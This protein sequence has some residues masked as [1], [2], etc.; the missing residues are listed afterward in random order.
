MAGSS[1]GDGGYEARQAAAEAKKQEARDAINLLFGQA[2]KGGTRPTREQFTMSPQELAQKRYL[3][4]LPLSGQPSLDYSG[5][6]PGPQI[7]DIDPFD[8]AAYNKALREWRQNQRA[9]GANRQGRNRLYNTVRRNAFDAGKRDLEENREQSARKLKFELFARGLNGG[10]EDIDQNALF[11]RTYSKGLIDLGAQADAARAG[12]RSD[13]ENTRLQLLGAIDAGMDQGSALSSAT[14]R[15]QVAADKAR[16]DAQGT[17][18]GNVFANA[19]LLY[20]QGQ[21]ALGRQQGQ[22]AWWNQYR[23]PG[24]QRSNSNAATG[25][26]TSV[27]G[28]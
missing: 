11:G 17:T 23:G 4:G 21:Y 13:D 7:P 28:E 2:P 1:G 5:A 19:G 25:W 16:A 9:I 12:F 18:L 10:S 26:Q 15:M 3:A 6:Q 22:Q 20:D 8:D 24:T 14:Q 27:P